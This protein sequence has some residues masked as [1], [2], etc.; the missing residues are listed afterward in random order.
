MGEYQFKKE[1]TFDNNEITRRLNIFGNN[2]TYLGIIIEIV[3]EI[4]ER[5]ETIEIV[6]DTEIEEME[7]TEFERRKRRK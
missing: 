4:T 7:V 5:T 2:R 1:G 6:K 3:I